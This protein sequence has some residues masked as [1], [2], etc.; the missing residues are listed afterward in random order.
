MEEAVKI[1]A[2]HS[3]ATKSQFVRIPDGRRQNGAHQT[4]FYFN[5]QT[6]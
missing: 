1:G 4:C 5:P 6:P 3:T 2:C